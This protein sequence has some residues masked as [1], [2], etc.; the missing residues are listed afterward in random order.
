[1]KRST[2]KEWTETTTVRVSKFVVKSASFVAVWKD[3]SLRK[4][5]E[6]AVIE[7]LVKSGFPMTEW[8]NE[9]MKYQK[10]RDSV[11]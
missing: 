9:L 6:D 1:M 11:G 8:L 4:V 2:E 5:V 10:W 7:A 3:E